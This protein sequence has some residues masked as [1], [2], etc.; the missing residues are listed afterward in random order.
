MTISA[1]EYGVPVSGRLSTVR[2]GAATSLTAVILLLLCWIS[3][4]ISPGPASHMYIALFSEFPA[5]SGTALVVGLCW[6]LVGG[7]ITGAIF[8]GVYNL[9][10]VIER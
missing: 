3:A 1:Q 9:L 4:A 5:T 8:A 6:S 7:F 10:A 2:V